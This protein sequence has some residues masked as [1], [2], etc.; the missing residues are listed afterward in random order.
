MTDIVLVGEEFVPADQASI[1]YRAQGFSY[2]ASV[3]EGIRGYWSD[4][5]G[6]LYI[7]RLDEHL[8]RLRMS[9]KM[10]HLGELWPVPELAERICE[11]VRRND[12]HEDIYIRPIAYKGVPENLGIVLSNTPNEFLAYTFPQGEYLS[13]DRS[14]KVITSSWTRISDNAAPA[15]AKIGGT[16]INPALAKTDAVNQ[17]ADECL[18]L[19]N[20]GAVAE[21]STSNLFLVT[22]GE[23]ITPASTE[24]I[25][26]GITRRTLMTLAADELNLQV[27]ERVVDRSELYQAD[28]IFLCGTGAEVAVVGEVDGRR[29]GSGRAG[30]VT[31][32]LQDVYRRTVRGSEDKY[33]E[34]L[35]PVYGKP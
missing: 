16:Y 25:L 27:R 1:D 8:H 20:S 19:N 4:V 9:A 7:F 31:R 34:W 17:G 18:M 29:V 21:G 28:E 30:E 2:G 22:A 32:A 15:R 5:E 11:L 26:V 33:K 10:L 24:D 12:L 23:L 6:Q 13:R 35:T 3:F 14:L